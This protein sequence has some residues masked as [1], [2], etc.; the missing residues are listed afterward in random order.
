MNQIKPK[1]ITVCGCDGDDVNLSKKGYH[2]AYQVG[3][4]IA[5]KKGIVVCGG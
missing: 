1:H 5:Q 3:E 4:L 2:I